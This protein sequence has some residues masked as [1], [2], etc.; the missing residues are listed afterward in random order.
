MSRSSASIRKEFCHELQFV[1]AFRETRQ[2]L[3]HIVEMPDK[4]ANLFIRLV[5]Q[6]RG[7]LSD[8]KRKS[9]FSALTD[10]EISRMQQAIQ[11]KLTTA[12]ARDNEVAG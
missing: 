6:N 12:L 11:Q 7:R 5:I 4:Q 3:E 1:V 8:A 2:E 10:G 9:L